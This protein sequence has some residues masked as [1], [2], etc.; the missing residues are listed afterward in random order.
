MKKVLVLTAVF[1]LLA[2]GAM[3]MPEG[4]NGL[5]VFFDTGGNNTCLLAPAPYTPLTAY[6]MITNPGASGKV[7]GWEG[8]L[9]INPPTFA[10]GITLDIGPEALNVFTAPAFNV[11]YTSVGV[12]QGNPIKLVTL[13]TFYLGGPISFGVGPTEPSS[14]HGAS[15]C[16]VDAVDNSLLVPLTP[17]CGFPW[18]FAAAQTY[19]GIVPHPEASYLVAGAGGYVCV[20]CAV[21]NE[22]SSWGGVK[23]LYR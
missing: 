20:S 22:P 1:S 18:P 15:A 5:G 23:A 6:L 19:G 7:A 8:Q 2:S 21:A 14:T 10:A 16:F 11:G 12:R 3:A 13:T 9:L 17:F 4:P